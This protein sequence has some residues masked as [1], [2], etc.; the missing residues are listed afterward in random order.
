[1][2]TAGFLSGCGPDRRGERPAARCPRPP[3]ESAQRPEA[4][5]T[6]LC[7]F[8]PDTV[9]VTVGTAKP[10]CGGLGPGCDRR[11][12]G[13][14]PAC[15]P[16]AEPP[17]APC[18]PARGVSGG[19]PEDSASSAV[20]PGRRGRDVALVLAPN[21]SFSPR[22]SKFRRDTCPSPRLRRG[23]GGG[24]PGPQGPQVR[25]VT[26]P[27]HRA[28]RGPAASAGRARGSAEAAH[29][30]L[31]CQ[32]EAVSG[33]TETRAQ[34]PARPP[35]RPAAQGPAYRTRRPWPGGLF[36]TL[37]G[38]ALLPFPV[39]PACGTCC[40]LEGLARDTPPPPYLM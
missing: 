27:G 9:T 5:A 36:P 14:R 13:T 6:W 15:P 4:A 37:R 35:L 26:A 24:V 19:T 2:A 39:P 34:T 25:R 29:G 18:R 30:N 21:P 31:L 11:G 28:W 33:R 16:A 22:E 32:G 7:H 20:K 3:R 12:T 10:R 23:A 40:L 8:P 1:M 17:C 38:W